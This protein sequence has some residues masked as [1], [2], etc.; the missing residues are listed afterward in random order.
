MKKVLTLAVVLAMC[1]C[2]CGESKNDPA[3]SG[4]TTVEITDCETPD[5]PAPEGAKPSKAVV[6]NAHNAVIC[7]VL[8]E[9][10]EQG[11]MV[12]M[13]S[14]DS[15]GEEM[16][17][18]EREYNA[19][20]NETKHCV[21]S[22]DKLVSR[23]E[24]KYDGRKALEKTVYDSEDSV[25]TTVKYEHDSDGN[26]IKET[27]YTDKGDAESVYEV[28]YGANGKESERT[29]LTTDGSVVLRTVYEYTDDGEP[30]KIMQYYGNGSLYGYFEYE[31]DANGNVTKMT[32]YGA[33]GDAKNITVYKYE[34]K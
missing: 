9:Y 3:E 19:D 32:D 20:G 6:Y 7:N 17:H 29:Q 22:K 27:R 12:K 21:Y 13:T 8:Y 10:D 5:E 28:V 33:D 26:V 18:T 4:G 30:L 23:E 1:L 11:R 15:D 25:S 2:G 24:T 31:H 14:T 34:S 16:S